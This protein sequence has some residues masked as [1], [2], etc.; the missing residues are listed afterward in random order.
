MSDEPRVPI[1]ERGGRLFPRGTIYYSRTARGFLEA[2]AEG[3][4]VLPLGRVSGNVNYYTAPNGVSRL[5]DQTGVFIPT[6]VFLPGANTNFGVG[7]I[8]IT[9]EV[10]IGDAYAVR[11]QNNQQMVERQT[12]LMP[13]GTVKVIEINHGIGKRFDDLKQGKQ[14]YR[15][16]KEALGDQY[17]GETSRE[18][19][20]FIMQDRIILRTN[21]GPVQGG[22]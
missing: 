11:V 5:R 4:G 20:A 18:L 14:W 10:V 17:G 12:L 9:E 8:R 22:F 7:T 13:D 3:E 6:G 21:L 16:M 1:D 2:G 19:H 15:K